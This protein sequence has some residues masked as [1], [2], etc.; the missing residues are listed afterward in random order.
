MTDQTFPKRKNIRLKEYDYDSAGAYF[1]TICTAN[2]RCY[3]WEAV[4][5][6]IARP[7]RLSQ[8]GKVVEKAIQNI[9]I[10]YAG[11]S[12]DKYVIMPNHLHLL[13]RIDAEENGRAMP[14]PTISTIIQQTKGYVT[15]QIGCSIWQSRFYDHVIRNQ[16]DYDDVYR[17]I[18]N[19]PTQWEQDELYT[20]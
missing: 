5:T 19:N 15:K 7:P 11:V 1:I 14:V 16:A 18:E 3:L 6:G 10:C 9:P 4:G 17:Y 20:K 13:L 2:R 12:V 8:Y